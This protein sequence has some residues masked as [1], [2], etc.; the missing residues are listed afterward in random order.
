MKE[1]RNGVCF[2]HVF[3]NFVHLM[4][5]SSAHG[6]LIVQNGLTTTMTQTIV[7][8]TFLDGE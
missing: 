5:N 7:Q 3:T 8:T 4:M 2:G 6:T 1:R